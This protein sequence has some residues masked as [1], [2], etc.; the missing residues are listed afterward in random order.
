[1]LT[2]EA[3]NK[4]KSSILHKNESDFFELKDFFISIKVNTYKTNISDNTCLGFFQSSS[5]IDE[6]NVYQIFERTN[7][8]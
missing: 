3:K 7:K 1:M 6:Q 5:S 2:S 4:N 8:N